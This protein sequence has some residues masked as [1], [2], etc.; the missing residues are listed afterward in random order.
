MKKVVFVVLSLVVFKFAKADTDYWYKENALWTSFLLQKGIT[1]KYYLVNEFRYR[2][3]ESPKN[4][5]QIIIRPS[6]NFKAADF[7]DLSVGVSYSYNGGYNQFSHFTDGNEFN[8]WEQFSTHQKI[9]WLDFKTRFRMEHRFTRP[10]F[11]AEY[12]FHNRLR[13]QFEIGHNFKKL[14]VFIYDELFWL[15]HAFVHQNWLGIVANYNFSKKW[16]VNLGLMNQYLYRE[17]L[18]YESNTVLRIGAKLTL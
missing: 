1:E 7:L 13:T 11:E 9:G 16:S 12:N 18:S 2:V 3:I 17:M 15:K 5:Q 8:F 14:G 4:L 10:N 6:V